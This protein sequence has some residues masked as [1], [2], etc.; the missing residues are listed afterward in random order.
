MSS[1]HV[2][3]FGI[4]KTPATAE[5]AVDHLLSI[6]FANE[7]ISVLLPMMKALVRSLTKRQPRLPKVQPPE[8]PL[9]ES[10]GAPWDCWL[11]LAHSQFRE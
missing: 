9:A 2:A 4:Y 8:P 7:S 5:A 11:A 10:L 3:V 6:G 1:K